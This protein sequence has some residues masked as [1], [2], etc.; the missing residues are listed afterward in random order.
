MGIITGSN[1]NSF[2]SAEEIYSKV[3]RDLKSFVGANLIDEGEFPIYTAEVLSELGISTAKECEAVL[4]ISDCKTK[5]PKGLQEI[6]AIYKCT[7]LKSSKTIWRGQGTNIIKQDVTCEV[8][9]ITEG[10][11]ILCSSNERIIQKIT[12]QVFIN[13]SCESMDYINPVL[14]RLSP[15]VKSKCSTNCMNLI[16]SAP[17]EISI[18]D[19]W[20]KTNFDNDCIYI[21]Y[22]G[23]PL[24]CDGRPMIPNIH[25]VKKAIEMYIKYQILLSFWYNSD[26]ADIQN[27]WNKAERDYLDAMSECRYILK[28][29]SF[30]T[31]INQA[32]INR[33]SSMLNFFN[34]RLS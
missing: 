28:L 23:F 2:V 22:Y 27:K 13:D 6:D 18:D 21:Q 29:P 30:S 7:P 9:G 12:T 16:S 14:L 26:V 34:S 1:K 24:D 19:G 32:R 3:R 15:N 20:F 17:F 5:V 8:L 11:N 33:S 10:C 4:E 31:L 25:Q